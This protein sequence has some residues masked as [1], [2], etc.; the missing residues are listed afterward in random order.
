[1]SYFS[2]KIQVQIDILM[3]RINFINTNQICFDV[4]YNYDCISL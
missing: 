4:L 3:K 2:N 1:M